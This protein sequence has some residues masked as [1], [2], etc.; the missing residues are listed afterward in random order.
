MSV[1]DEARL[2]AALRIVLGATGLVAP[3]ALG[4]PWV[5]DDVDNPAARVFLRGLAARDVILGG[6]ALHVVDRPGVGRRTFATVAA[7]DA[8]DAL[9][10]LAVRDELPRGKALLAAAFAAGGAVSALWVARRLPTTADSSAGS[11]PR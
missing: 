6:L 8:A 2:L 10:T 5:G 4:R 9:A 3:R 7:A 1:R 11:T